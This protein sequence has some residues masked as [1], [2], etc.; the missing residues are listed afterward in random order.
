[1]QWTRIQGCRS[2]LSNRKA[3]VHRTVIVN[4]F[5]GGGSGRGIQARGEETVSSTPH[6][7]SQ[8]SRE[9]TQCVVLLYHACL[10]RFPRLKWLSDL[11]SLRF[12]HTLYPLALSRLGRSLRPPSPTQTSC[13]LTRLDRHNA[14]HS[15]PYDFAAGRGQ[16]GGPNHTKACGDCLSEPLNATFLR[17][18]TIFLGSRSQRYTRSRVLWC[19]LSYLNTNNEET[20][21]T[22]VLV[23]R[24]GIEGVGSA[25]QKEKNETCKTYDISFPCFALCFPEFGGLPLDIRVAK[26]SSMPLKHCSRA[27]HAGW[28][29][30]PRL[31]GKREG[32]EGWRGGRG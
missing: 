22:V 11:V 23:E 31:E 10:S 20:V 2:T 7:N 18:S 21:R 5:R 13:P 25:Q 27:A 29:E 32:E 1:M 17:R 16:R 24:E 30:A 19:D 15:L 6:K 3:S 4:T 14:N 12:L 26:G 28:S 9:L 8:N